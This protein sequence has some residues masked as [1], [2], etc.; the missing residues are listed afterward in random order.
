[1]GRMPDIQRESLIHDPIHGYIPFISIVDEGETSE[2]TLL[3][4]A[5]LQRLRQIYQL[6][7]FYHKF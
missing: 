5:W 7:G 1:M 2:R 3:D 4:H 6:Q